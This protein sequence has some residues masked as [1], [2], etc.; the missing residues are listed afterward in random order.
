VAALIT[1]R[2]LPC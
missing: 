1:D 2:N